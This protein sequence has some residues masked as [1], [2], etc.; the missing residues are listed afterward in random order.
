MYSRRKETIAIF[1]IAIALFIS[2]IYYK[3]VSTALLNLSAVIGLQFVLLF[4][5]SIYVFILKFKYLRMEMSKDGYIQAL[6]S[7]KYKLEDE[8]HTLRNKT[9]RK[10]KSKF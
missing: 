6:Q 3:E 8:V 7:A 1:L 5:L 4:I 9:K 10:T 2:G